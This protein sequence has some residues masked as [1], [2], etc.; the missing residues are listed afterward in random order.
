M[1]FRNDKRHGSQ[2]ACLHK[3]TF[4]RLST[5]CAILSLISWRT[6]VLAHVVDVKPTSAALAYFGN[7][8][9][10]F[11]PCRNYSRRNWY[12]YGT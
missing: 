8:K 10:K 5:S 7:K 12:N 11:L 9:T 6:H 1:L 4:V 2:R 3:L